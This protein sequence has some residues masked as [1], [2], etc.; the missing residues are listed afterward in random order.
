MC[1]SLRAK[2]CMLQCN[3]RIT[4]LL[5]F[6]VQ[7]QETI[8][9]KEIRKFALRFKVSAVWFK[10]EKNNLMYSDLFNSC[11]PAAWRSRDCS[12]C[13]FP[14]PGSQKNIHKQ[15]VFPFLDSMLNVIISNQLIISCT[16]S[17]GCSFLF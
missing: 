1:T 2:G 13:L 17:K 16:V 3:V 14:V 11:I 9:Q 5:L 6:K 8:G 7:H 12:R 4:P 15:L 10:S